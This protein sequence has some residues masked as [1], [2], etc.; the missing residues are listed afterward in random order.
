[1]VNEFSLK[2]FLC[3]VMVVKNPNAVHLSPAGT[4]FR[5]SVKRPKTTFALPSNSTTPIIMIAAGTGLSP[6]RGFLRQRQALGLKSTAKGGVSN[7]YLFFGCSHI[8]QDIIYRD[9]LEAFVEDGNLTALHTAFSRHCNDPKRYV[10]HH[11]MA[12]ASHV[13]NFI[14]EHK[15]IIYICGAGM[16]AGHLS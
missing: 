14:S 9:E 7:A 12:N 4:T 6:F 1:M 15:A 10:Q 2:E 13:W 11:I 16:Y 5:A 3:A 8:D